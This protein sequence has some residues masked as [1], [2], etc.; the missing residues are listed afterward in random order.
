MPDSSGSIMYS[1]GSYT[2]MDLD[3]AENL[4]VEQAVI[5]LALN[6]QRKTDSKIEIMM[7]EAGID[8]DNTLKREMKQ[9]SRSVA[10]T[11][12]INGYKILQTKMS[13]L[14]NGKYITFVV[15]EFPLSL[16]WQAYLNNL[17]KN[18]VVKEKLTKIKNT[19]SFKELEQSVAEFTGA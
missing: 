15:I 10:K 19:D 13:Q 5:K 12:S 7:R 6:L 9:I 4:A 1:R 14:A 18:E 17:E 8:Q 11:V 2:A 3:F 16:N